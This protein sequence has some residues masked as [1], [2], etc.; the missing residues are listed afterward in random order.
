[1]ATDSG[2]DMEFARIA[3]E[4]ARKSVPEDDRIHPKVGV[5]VVKEERVLAMAHRGESPACHAEF[6]ALEQKLRDESLSGATVYTTLEPCTTRSHPKIPCASRLA[7]RRVD[8]VVIGML[9]PNPT[10]CGKGQMALRDARIATVFFPRELMAEVEEL[11]REF[12]RANRR[13]LGEPPR[14]GPDAEILR[15]RAD[16]TSLIYRLYR[17]LQS[18]LKDVHWWASQKDGKAWKQMI[19]M[20]GPSS[21]TNT[22]ATIEKR[23]TPFGERLWGESGSYPAFPLM[24][25]GPTNRPRSFCPGIASSCPKT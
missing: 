8:R 10:I 9:D 17:A 19:V 18:H 13:A 7:E 15:I 21:R 4:E 5:V 25:R 20:H 22:T 11:N 16:A 14:S 6:V 3:V 1:M 12:V 23:W 24:W 2:K